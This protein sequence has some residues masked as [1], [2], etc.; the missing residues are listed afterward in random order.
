MSLLTIGGKAIHRGT[1]EIVS[2]PVTKDLG[3]EI[4]IKAHILAG[5]HE[6]P[7]FLLL[8][9]LHGEE[10]FSMLILRELVRIIDL[11][12]LRGNIIAIPVANTSAFNTGTRCV[13]DNSD[14]PDAN[15]AFGG[16]YQWLTNQITRVIDEE[17]MSKS[18]YM[19]DYHVGTWGCTMA[20][21]GYGA[22]YPD[23]K[24]SEISREMALAY[25][26]PVIH[27]MKLNKGTHSKR[28]SMGR[29]ALHHSIPAIV[30]EIGGLGFGEN[31]EKAWLEDNIRGIMGN[32]KYLGMI[33][34]EPDYC[35]KYLFVGDYWRVSPKN[36]GYLEP[37]IG[38]DRQF[39]RVEKGE[40]LA[41]VIDPETFE[42]LEELR[43]PGE[44]AIFY[45][46]RSY[47]TR[48]GGWAYGIACLEDDNSYWA[49][50]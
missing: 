9:M 6:G 4:N 16:E 50:K 45:T 29:A 19:I 46:C 21:I 38:L 47:M 34:G 48:P 14:E 32:L 8:S 28:T 42:V 41:R 36:G 35:D 5:R 7:T 17:F 27:Q 39:T 30:P 26:F 15:R 40:L 13:M 49:S 33:D 1:K 2:V 31:I 11:N 22:D 44:G 18:D 3:V 37:V 43:S 20:D 12:E 10:W 24:L 23:P 25:Q